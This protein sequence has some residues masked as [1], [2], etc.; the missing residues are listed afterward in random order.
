MNRDPPVVCRSP[1][2]VLP[3]R[4][5]SYFV[6]QYRNNVTGTGRSIPAKKRSNRHCVLLSV[7]K[8]K[9]HTRIK[10]EEC[11]RR[12]EIWG[13]NILFCAPPSKQNSPKG[14]INLPEFAFADEAI[15]RLFRFQSEKN[16]YRWVLLNLNTD[17]SKSWW[18]QSLLE[19]IN[20]ISCVLN[21]TLDW[22]FTQIE[23]FSLG[24]V[25]SDKAG[26][27]WQSIAANSLQNFCLCSTRKH[28]RSHVL[29]ISAFKKRKS[30]HKT[31]RSLAWM[32]SGLNPGFFSGGKTQRSFSSALG[33]PN[34]SFWSL[35]NLKRSGLKNFTCQFLKLRPHIQAARP[36]GL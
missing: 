20:C 14:Q 3:Y 15:Q 11:A 16:R 2:A 33:G 25:C 4:A 36:P 30:E 34:F 28:P 21:C 9:D 7:L 22:K 1:R 24:M 18:I 35:F 17:K 5:A 12:K 13:K 8:N 26:S 32:Q 10:R 31:R 29:G 23:G 27:T 6:L 19:I